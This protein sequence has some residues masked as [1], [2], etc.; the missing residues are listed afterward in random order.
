MILQI[1]TKQKLF[2]GFLQLWILG[3]QVGAIYF[4]CGDASDKVDYIMMSV[5]IIMSLTKMTAFRANM[6]KLREI[7]Q[8]ALQDWSS[9]S[10]A[11]DNQ[12]MRSFAKIGRKV[13]KFQ[14]IFCYLSNFIIFVGALPFL[15]PPADNATFG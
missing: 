6:P 2:N 13:F 12:R 14:I 15:M 5:C 7:V 4:N 3:L 11:E 9:I 8:C 1:H 10:T